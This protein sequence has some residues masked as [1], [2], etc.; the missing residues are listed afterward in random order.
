MIKLGDTG[1]SKLYLGDTAISRAYIG[2]ELVFQEKKGRLPAGYTE[3]EYIQNSNTS[4]YIN[5]NKSINDSDFT[6]E[7]SAPQYEFSSI[8]NYL[9]YTRDFYLTVYGA[10][11]T[12]R[13]G[14]GSSYKNYSVGKISTGKITVT[15]SGYSVLANGVDVALSFANYGIGMIFPSSFGSYLI[16]RI[17]SFKATNKNYP[18][19]KDFNFDLIPC[20][21]PDGIVGLYD[22]TNAEFIGPT[23]GTYIA[24][25][26]I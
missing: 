2:D 18:T 17:Y 12:L 19:H 16:I 5:T 1:V 23:A 8:T 24:G 11:L 21:N 14:V 7:I 6:I 15:G 20:I 4:S 10:D 26:A 3:V 22:L 13:A 9:F 25:P